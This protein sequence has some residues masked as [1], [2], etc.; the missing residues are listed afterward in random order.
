MNEYIMMA[1]MQPG[2]IM[3]IVVIA[4]IVLIVFASLKIKNFKIF[5][6]ILKNFEYNNGII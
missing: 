4:I 5:I 3:A 6:D 1:A 2:K